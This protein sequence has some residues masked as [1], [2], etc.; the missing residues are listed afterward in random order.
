MTASPST[1]GPGHGDPLRM[2]GEAVIAI[3]EAATP[4]DVLAS[5]TPEQ[6]GGHS[7]YSASSVRY[8]LQRQASATNH[9]PP[10]PKRW[11]FDRG[12]LLLATSDAVTARIREATERSVPRYLAALATLSRTGDLTELSAA[13]TA[14]LDEFSPGGSSDG[15][16]GN[17][18]RT[19]LLLLAACD[20]DSALAA[21]LRQAQ[22]SRLALYEAVYELAMEVTG[23]ELREGITV[24]QLTVQVNMLLEGVSMRRRFEPAIDQSVVLRAVLAIFWGLTRAIDD[25]DE[26]EP[27]QRL[28]A[29]AR[30]RG[31]G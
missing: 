7:G 8:Q 4:G 16:A 5:V 13:L 20:G 26:L 23:R 28:A 31:R 2:F 15:S 19:L 3:V 10:A 18:E 22:S 11:S 30:R 25:P 29:T 27:A 9:Q 1:Q 17:T 21:A 24:Q 6:I 14:D 12:R